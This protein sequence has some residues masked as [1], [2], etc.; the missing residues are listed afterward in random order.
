LSK[1]YSKIIHFYRRMLYFYRR[2][3]S[4]TRVPVIPSPPFLLGRNVTTT[5]SPPQCLNTCSHILFL[6]PSPR[7]V[8]AIDLAFARPPNTSVL[9][10]V[11]AF[12][13]GIIRIIWLKTQKES[14]GRCYS[15]AGM[16]RSLG[17]VPGAP[18]G[19]NTGKN[20]ADARPTHP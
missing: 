5:Q 16:K 20:K 12:S 18:S 3:F 15:H 10:A 2:I 4:S 19:P 8:T 9:A 13:I 14:Q 7:L 11:N 6:V 1:K 17:N